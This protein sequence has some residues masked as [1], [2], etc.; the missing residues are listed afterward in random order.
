MLRVNFSRSACVGVAPFWPKGY[1]NADTWKKFLGKTNQIFQCKIMF[2]MKVKFPESHK[3][4]SSYKFFPE[5]FGKPK[6]G[7][8]VKYCCKR[9]FFGK[10][11]LVSQNTFKHIKTIVL[12]RVRVSNKILNFSLGWFDETLWQRIVTFSEWGN[13]SQKCR[14]RAT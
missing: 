11:T 5:F 1:Q 8:R 14:S 4:F 9:K 10:H 7:W 3:K 13:D 2:E 12:P 6:H